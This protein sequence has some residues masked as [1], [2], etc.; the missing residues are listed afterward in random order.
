MANVGTI[1]PDGI[2]NGSAMDDRI[3]RT[4][5]MAGPH[6]ANMVQIHPPKRSPPVWSVSVLWWWSVLLT[7]VHWSSRLGNP[8][9]KD[10]PPWM[11]LRQLATSLK[12]NPGKVVHLDTPIRH[13]AVAVIFRPNLDLLFIKRAEF[14]GDPWSGHMALPGGGVEPTDVDGCA[15]VIR[16]VSEEVGISLDGAELLGQMGQV[17]SPVMTSRVIVTPFVFKLQTD[18]QLCLDG[19]EVAAAHWFSIE[20]LLAN[21]GRGVFDYDYAGQQIELSRVDLDGERVWGM[22]LGIVDEL[23]ERIRSET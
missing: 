4:I 5:M 7:F 8:S 23:L 14:D 18:P 11:M 19:K 13:A 12:N 6:D 2:R 17:A 1:D 15:A 3:N 22:T 9:A 10:Y 21:E 20:R 16:E